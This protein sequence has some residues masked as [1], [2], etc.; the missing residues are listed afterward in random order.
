VR[1]QAEAEASLDGRMLL[2]F[3]VQD[4]G[5]GIAPHEIDQVFEPFVQTQSGISKQTGT[6]LGV[7]LS[8]DFARLLGGD[9]TLSSQPG[10]G[11][12]FR[13]AVRV[14]L[15]SGT[16]LA[17]SS[18]DTRRV[19]ALDSQSRLTILIVDDQDD[20]RAFLRELLSGAGVQVVEAA[21]GAAA[22]A[23][24]SEARPDLVFMDVKMPGMDGVEATR[25]IR[26][27]EQGAQVPIV[28][29]SASVFNDD[30]SSVLHTGANQF[31][32]K[33]FQIA[34][35]WAT[36]ERYLHV[37]LLREARAPR[38]QRALVD[39]TRQ[40]VCALDTTALTAVRE[41]MA[42]GY[43]QRIPTLLAGLG[44]EHGRTVA[45]LSKLAEELEIETLNDLLQAPVQSAEP[46]V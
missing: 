44:A 41:A 6:G 23:H 3:A 15:G 42:L 27:L 35:I 17:T 20:N 38:P 18:A 29:L 12:I 13:L 36:L 34:E 46:T 33:P 31:I 25:R 10:V 11:T 8:R 2:R 26:M 39:L 14:E 7:T 30:R 16:E 32:A 43:V 1:L 9:L 37:K 40:Q 5:V 22:V 45:L 24:C 4:T 19:I 21:D 28:M